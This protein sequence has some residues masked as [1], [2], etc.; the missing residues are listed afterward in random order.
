MSQVFQTQFTLRFRQADPAQIMFFGHILGLAHDAYEDFIVALGYSW[1]DW[2]R[3]GDEIVPIRHAETDFLI[4]FQP[5]QT[6]DI[7]VSVPEIRETSFQTSYVFSQKGRVHATVKLVH[8]VI[9]SET[10]QKKPLPI[11]MRQRLENYLEAKK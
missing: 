2:F 10:L 8:A 1:K 9:D 5:G 7:T 4:P 11:L 6:Y 3:R